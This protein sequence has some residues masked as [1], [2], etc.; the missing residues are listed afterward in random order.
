[1]FLRGCKSITATEFSLFKKRLI[2][3]FSWLDDREVSGG[4]K[5]YHLEDEILSSP[6][7]EVAYDHLPIHFLYKYNTR[8][9][10]YYQEKAIAEVC[11]YEF[12]WLVEGENAGR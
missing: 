11:K 2:I 6:L 8:V 1:M 4:V 12:K 10:E 5:W 7:I 3:R 9:Y